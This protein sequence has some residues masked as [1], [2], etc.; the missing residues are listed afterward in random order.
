MHVRRPSERHK[1]AR[2]AETTQ[3]RT[4]AHEGVTIASSC[5]PHRMALSEIPDQGWA[6]RLGHIDPHHFGQ[7]LG[8]PAAEGKRD[9]VEAA[10][11][12]DAITEL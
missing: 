6:A 8:Q 10:L 3:E 1:P 7:Q 12:Q 2:E 11:D 5:Q 4:L 9:L